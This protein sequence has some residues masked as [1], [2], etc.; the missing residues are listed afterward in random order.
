MGV[1]SR[2][3]YNPEG[4][5]LVQAPGDFRWSGD[6]APGFPIV[7]ERDGSV[8]EPLVRFFGYS[9]ATKRA[10]LSSLVTEAYVLREWWAYL[11]KI[12]RRWNNVDDQVLKNWR[13]AM[14][15]ENRRLKKERPE[16]WKKHLIS[17][18]RIAFKVNTV[19]LFYDKAKAVMLL[20]RDMVS[21]DG[22]MTCWPQ[23]HGGLRSSSFSM[24]LRPHRRKRSTDREWKF[25]EI[26]TRNTTKRKTPDGALVDEVLTGLRNAPENEVIGE[27]DWLIGRLMA[28]AGLRVSEVVRFAGE[29]LVDPLNMELR[30]VR[31]KMPDVQTASMFSS[32]L[33]VLD[34]MATWPEGQKVILDGL[35]IL[36][37]NYRT[38]IYIEVMGKGDVIRSAP[39]PIKLVRD[40]LTVG[41]WG[42]RRAQIDGWS[43][44]RHRFIPPHELFLSAKTKQPL[45]VRSVGDL[46]KDA[47]CDLD[48][49]QLSG[50]RLR[51]YFATKLASRLWAEQFANNGFRWD[52]AVVNTVIAEV[53]QALG[54]K[55]PT[56]TIQH[57]VDSGIA[58]YFGTANEP[59]I[60]SMQ[61]VVQA[62]AANHRT[63]TASLLGKIAELTER[64]GE[65]DMDTREKL[66]AMISFILA[67]S[68]FAGPT[69]S[70]DI[71]KDICQPLSPHPTMI[72][73]QSGEVGCHADSA[74]ASKG[75][76]SGGK[77]E[78]S[79]K[80][81]RKGISLQLVPKNHN[82]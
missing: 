20:E 5:R 10:K 25:A 22:P 41:I 49:D 18:T 81:R 68:E 23:M 1:A 54:H 39:F 71:E 34:N 43:T 21:S 45:A 66:E 56:T 50:H 38:N 36:E 65:L 67:D 9:F 12:H 74:V 47:F 80:G 52:Q 76:T 31:R 70:N 30:K 3:K 42:F 57:Y 15:D 2:L 64:A 28:E 29:M 7:C 63:L 17:E 58:D 11:D 72:I 40:I 6:L 16:G 48:I 53:S 44:R 77:E 4:C 82:P 13:E 59:K 27:R 19:F 32:Q 78:K 33:S 14:K 73:V 26:S 60:R 55:L 69:A 37:R 46:V 8:C 35:E 79:G 51:A 24:S 75:N 62:I 61:R